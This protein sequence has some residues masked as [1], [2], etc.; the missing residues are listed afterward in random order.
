MWL[1]ALRQFGQVNLGDNADQ[2]AVATGLWV[3]THTLYY[4][5][6][7]AL[8]LDGSEEQSM[9][10]STNKPSAVRPEKR[11]KRTK[12]DDKLWIG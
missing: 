2:L 8:P 9:P 12:L 7:A 4:R 5:A 11:E 6:A 10:T 3:N 1:Q